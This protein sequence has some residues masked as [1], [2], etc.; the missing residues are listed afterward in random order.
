MFAVSGVIVNLAFR[1]SGGEIPGVSRVNPVPPQPPVN[2]FPASENKGVVPLAAGSANV[3]IVTD[4]NAT[5]DKA[6]I[7]TRA[8]RLAMYERRTPFS[9]LAAVTQVER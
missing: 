4:P 8:T 1:K 6:R 2:W 9:S 7:D 5:V 3:A